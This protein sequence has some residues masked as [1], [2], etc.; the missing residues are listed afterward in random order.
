MK[1]NVLDDISLSARILLLFVC[2]MACAWG[3]VNTTI[4]LVFAG[5]VGFPFAVASCAMSNNRKQILNITYYTV[6][7]V[8]L[9][10]VYFSFT[11]HQISESLTKNFTPTVTDFLLAVGLGG[12]LSYFWNHVIRINIIVMSAGLSS[13]LPAC[14]MTGYWISNGSFDLAV[15]SLLLHFE[16]VIGILLGAVIIDKLGVSK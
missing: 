2:G 8:L 6:F 3:F 12:A 7:L 16:Y 15:S 1:V 10:F 13:L 5:K 4:L 11:H 9:G 14:I